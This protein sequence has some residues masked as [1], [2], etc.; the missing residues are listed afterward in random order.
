MAAPG[1][2][3]VVVMPAF[4]EAESVHDVVGAVPRRICGLA[5]EVIVIDDGSTDG[6]GRQAR[7]A[8]ALVCRLP[9]NLGQGQALRLGYRLARERGAERD[10]HRGRRRPVRSRASCPPW[11]LRS[12]P[13]R[14]TSS[15]GPG[16]SGGPRQQTPVRRIGV[17]LFGALVT[18]LTRVRITDPANGLRAFRVE[19]V[20]RVPLRQTQYQTAEL[21]DR[22][23]Q[24]RLP[25]PG[26]AG[27]GL[28][29]EGGRVQ[30]GWQPSLRLPVRAGGAHDL[31]VCAG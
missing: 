11:W 17:V 5:S 19:V 1:R 25:G 20:E 4:N 10:R 6:T 12:S 14:R 18:V 8:G 23:H 3:I 31:V 22:R 21:L 16:V 26:G 29:P 24:P 28:R 15:T 27:D 2:A 7:A 30:E 13:E 9:V